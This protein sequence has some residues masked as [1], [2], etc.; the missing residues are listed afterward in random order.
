MSPDAHSDAN[1]IL[2][3]AVFLAFILITFVFVLRAGRTTS[4]TAAGFYTGDAG[5]TGRQNGLAITGDALSAAAF[6]GVVGSISTFGY[7]GLLYSVGFFVPWIFSV[8]LTSEPLRNVGRFTVADMLAFRLKQ[9]PVRVGAAVV[10][11]V[12]SLFYLVAQMAGAGSLV[13]VLLDVHDRTAQALLVAAIGAVM[14]IYVLIGGMKGTTFI[15]MLKAVLLLGC[16]AV[17]GVIILT[18]VRG[19]VSE[20]L[21]LAVDA[22]GGDRGFLAP[23]AQ[24]GE[25]TLSRIDFVSLAITLLLGGAALPHVAMRFYTVPTAR[26]ARSSAAWAVAL[27]GGFFLVTIL[28]GFAAAAYVGPEAIEAAPGGSNS[29]ALLLAQEL[30]GP[31]FMALVSAIAFATVLAVV[32]GLAITAA[33]SVA[34]DFYNPVFRGGRASGD[35]QV[36]VSR[37]VVVVLGVTSTAL[38]IGAMDLNVAFLVALA[39]CVAGAANLP[40]ILF[41]LYWRRF[42]TT[43]A[44]ASMSVGTAVTVLLIVFSPLVSG[45]EDSLFPGV[46]FAFFPLENPGIVAIPVGFAAAIIG[47]LVGPK[48]DFREL[49]A[50]MEV[51]SLTGIGM[52]KPVAH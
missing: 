44:V 33:A 2:N 51:R 23:G 21:D 38:G 31:I 37:L 13:A 10:T 12:F 11:L 50:E 3:L 41:S 32:A 9:K 4:K 35:E 14:T 17:M 47:T 30:A 25:S 24:F 6:L 52:A 49:Q 45:S 19:N 27:I 48:E 26:A 1:P 8:L 28:L 39:F 5:F 43:G 34:R 40:T 29:A 36:R 46:D 7:D 42:T 22:H 16:V 18:M 15:Q 20:L